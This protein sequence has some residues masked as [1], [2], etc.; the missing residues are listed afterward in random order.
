MK[1]GLDTK[2]FDVRDNLEKISTSYEKKQEKADPTRKLR[3][4][5]AKKKK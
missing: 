2:L 3:V 1:S 4:T 5:K